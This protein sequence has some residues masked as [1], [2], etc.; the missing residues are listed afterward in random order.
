MWTKSHRVP[1]QGIL[2]ITTFLNFANLNIMLILILSSAL[3]LA[4][5]L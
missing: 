3:D 5:C 1:L 4:D 2:N